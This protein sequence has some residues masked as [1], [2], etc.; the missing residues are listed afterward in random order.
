M[1]MEKI[2]II[3]PVY[4]TG[5]YLDHFFSQMIHQTFQDYKA[6]I[7][8]DI[9]T[10]NSLE[11]IHN[12]EKKYPDHFE[13]LYSPKKNGLGA[14]RD[15]ALNSGKINGDYVLFLDPDDYPDKLFLEKMYYKAIETNADIT[16]CGFERFNDG[17]DRTLCLEMINNP[18]E[19]IYNIADFDLLAYMNPVV[20]D[21][22]YKKDLIGKI[23]FTEI[24]RTEDVFWL[25]RLIPNIK[26]IA[27]INEAIYHYRVRE[28]S[29]LN[30][31]SQENY[32]EVKSAFENLSLELKNN[33]ISETKYWDLI[34]LIVFCR[35]GIGVTYRASNRT[36]Y[37]IL[38]NETRYFLDTYYKSWRTNKFLKFNRARKYGIKG[39]AIWGC[40]LLYK[41][42]LF[43]IYIYI[44]SGLRKL[45]KKEIRW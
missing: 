8:Y 32:N 28:D 17:D 24:K 27:F 39:L 41:L 35:F 9:S 40:S 36:N 18:N 31:F 11:I 42:H 1:M 14:A 30:T 23:R 12:Y 37:K 45:S 21:K 43:N 5:K 7:V 15:F 19:V 13:V 29:L 26:S 6:Y 25:I 33:G 20:W 16:V 3:I 22:L 44:Y 34:V 2:S 10:D 4:N 38:E